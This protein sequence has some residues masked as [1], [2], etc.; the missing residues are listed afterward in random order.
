MFAIHCNF[1][2]CGRAC[3]R[4]IH[5]GWLTSCSHVF[6]HEHAEMWFPSHL[7]C[8]VC[9]TGKACRVV[10]VDL[11]KAH[12]EKELALL[13]FLPGEAL[14]AASEAFR[15]WAFQKT[16]ES[17]WSQDEHDDLQL[18]R[19]RL[20]HALTDR[21]NEAEAAVQHLSQKS[22]SLA[23]ELRTASAQRDSLQEQLRARKRAVGSAGLVMTDSQEAFSE[24]KKQQPRATRLAKTAF[25][26]D[27]YS[28]RPSAGLS[29][30]CMDWAEFPRSYGADF[31][32]TISKPGTGQ[33]LKD[34]FFA[35]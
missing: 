24:A 35:A 32:K 7:E 31:W 3:R 1:K 15:F 8:P 12:K 9:Q 30:S 25:D 2:Q 34:S 6:C 13:G 11:N 29:Q 4:R 18:Q 33:R 5:I 19:Q 28:V 14:E 26:A 10:K 21:S 27:E 23:R 20:K 16:L 17:D 22:M